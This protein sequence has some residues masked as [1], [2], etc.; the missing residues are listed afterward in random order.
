MSVKAFNKLLK[1]K[2]KAGRLES[3]IKILHAQDRKV[4]EHALMESI[5]AK[6]IEMTRFIMTNS[7]HQFDQLFRA[8]SPLQLAITTRNAN[9]VAMLLDEFSADINYTPYGDSPLELANIAY[10]QQII[11]L[12]TR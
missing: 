8:Y 12:L 3:I 11:A 7:E 9:M 6:D 4:I 5:L 2:S 1:K 10:S